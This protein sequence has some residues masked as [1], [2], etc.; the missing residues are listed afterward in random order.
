[1]KDR[2]HLL[3]AAMCGGNFQ[4]L[5][6]CNDAVSAYVERIFRVVVET[7]GV[8]VGVVASSG[9]ASQDLGCLE[10]ALSELL[11]PSLAVTALRL[12]DPLASSSKASQ[13]ND[14]KRSRDQIR[15]DEPAMDDVF[16]HSSKPSEGSV[17]VFHRTRLSM[18]RSASA[19]LC[20]E[21][22]EIDPFKDL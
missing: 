6:F 21:L 11:K 4:P 18:Q 10:K 13:S 15:A 20:R 8:E 16:M 17:V 7:R 14:S 19:R 5:F 3:Q 22:V 9:K 1:M 2:V 12:P